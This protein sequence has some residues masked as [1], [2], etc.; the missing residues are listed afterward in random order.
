MHFKKKYKINNKPSDKET[1]VTEN[2]DPQSIS[3]DTYEQQSLEANSKKE[4]ESKKETKP[5]T[6][7]TDNEDN[8]FKTIDASDSNSKNS[9]ADNEEPLRPGTGEQPVAGNKADELRTLSPKTAL[10]KSVNVKALKKLSKQNRKKSN[11]DKKQFKLFGIHKVKKQSGSVKTLPSDLARYEPD[12]LVGLSTAQVAE[13]T[14][15]ELT[16]KTKVSNSKSYLKIVLTNIFTF[17]NMIEWAIAIVLMVFQRY[18]S[19]LFIWVAV[20]NTIIGIV[21]ECRAK[22]TI[23]KLKLVTAQNIKVVRAGKASIISADQLVLDDI[24]VL[25]NGDQIPTDSIL[26]EGSMEVNESLLT[27]ESLPIKKAVGDSILAGSFVVSGSAICQAKSIGDYNYASG[28]QAKAKEYAKPQ[29]ELLRSLNLIIRVVALIILPVGGALFGTQW[30]KLAADNPT[31][32]SWQIAGE[33]FGKVSG[34]MIGMI[35]AGMYLLTSVALAAGVMSLAKKNTLVQ[36]LY[37]IEMLARV[38]ILCLDKTGTL[39]DG[40]MKVDEVL[41]INKDFDLNMVMGSYLNSFHENNQTSI[42]LSQRY[43]LKKDYIPRATIPFSSARKFSAVTFED[44]GTFILG[45]PEYIYKTKDRTVTR[46]IAEKESKGFRVVMLC[47]C[48]KEIQHN[49]IDGKIY[50]VAV[51]VLEDHIRPEAPN[52]IKWFVDNGVKIK[53]ISGDNPLTAS[54]IAQKCKVPEAEKCIS[55]EGLSVREVSDIVDKYTVFGRVS[56]EQKAA[57]IK[58]LKKEKNTVGMTGDGVNDILA[59]KNADCSIAMANGASAARNVAHLVLLDSNFAS[60]PSVVQEGRRVINNIQ[61]SSSLFLMKTIFTIVFTVIVLLTFL[62]HG[63]GIEYPFE[64]NNIMIMEV[65]GI[66]APSFFLALQKND[67][68]ITGHFLKNTFSRALPGAICLILAIALNY[69][70]KY[71]GNFLDPTGIES[72]DKIAFTT[73]CSITM[74]VISMAMVYSCCSPFNTYRRVL[75]IALW[76]GFII[77]VFV[78]PYL[79]AMANQPEGKNYTYW[80]MSMEFTGIDFRYMNKTMWLLLI[81]YGTG[82]SALLGLLMVLFSPMRGEGG[83]VFFKAFFGKKKLAKENQSESKNCTSTTTVITQKEDNSNTAQQ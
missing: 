69:V 27:G 53:I 59:M 48:D 23:D 32:T 62:N 47:H 50:P 65:I 25:N 70:F 58:Q 60:M 75:Y 74:A 20:V 39:T 33:A 9:A 36:D 28:L 37:C 77:F 64:T 76:V 8:E 71:S 82:V 1:E 29:S 16:N 68:L 6:N 11:K 78:L 14:A 4:E 12:I 63:N 34:S 41:V 35:P 30:I 7:N 79:P 40:T 73:F 61:R 56:P 5:V 54:E 80:N 49:E 42:A 83:S 55:L 18:S 19:A 45:A 24:Y 72:Y 15:Q 67:Q 21:Q 66:G 31:W 81:I 10:M 43:P 3:I 52:T 46:Y 17:F 2:K 22:Q 26:K 38:N 51:F 57:I 44:L 13:R